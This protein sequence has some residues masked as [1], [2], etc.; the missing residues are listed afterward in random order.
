MLFWFSRAGSLT[1]CDISMAAMAVYRLAHLL[2]ASAIRSL[3]LVWVSSTRSS[4]AAV[5][6]ISVIYG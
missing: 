3:S 2:Q 6:P 5:G 1:Q 4:M